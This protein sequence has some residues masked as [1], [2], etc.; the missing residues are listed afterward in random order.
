MPN[1]E[2]VRQFAKQAFAGAMQRSRDARGPSNA[3]AATTPTEG[4]GPAPVRSVYTEAR[5]AARRL[6]DE[7][8][9]KREREG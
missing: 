7:G 1:R 9:I 8:H 2:Y 5:E 3:T 4:T 6:I